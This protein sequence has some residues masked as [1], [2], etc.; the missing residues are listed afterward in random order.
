MKAATDFFPQ[1]ILHLRLRIGK[2]PAYVDACR[3]R[4][5]RSTI[6]KFRISSHNLAIERGCHSNTPRN[7]CLCLSCYIGAAEDEVHFLILVQ[8]MN[9]LENH[10]CRK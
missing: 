7:N 6:C 1:K 3:L 8:P 5:D 2:W 4:A 9:Q 10:F